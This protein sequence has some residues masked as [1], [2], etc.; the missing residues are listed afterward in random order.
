MEGR[1]S[2]Y[3]SCQS[4]SHDGF[5]T[6]A[7]DGTS[8][9]YPIEETTSHG[10]GDMKSRCYCITFVAVVACVW[11]SHATAQSSGIFV[12]PQTGNAG[13][14]TQ[15]PG[16]KLDIRQSA[17]TH[18]P[19]LNLETDTQYNSPPLP[20]QPPQPSGV[21]VDLELKAYSEDAGGQLRPATIPPDPTKVTEGTAQIRVNADHAIGLRKLS[22]GTA[23][24]D[25]PITFEPNGRE[26]LRIDGAGRVGIGTA[27]PQGALHIL[28]P[29][30]PP[31]A[32]DPSQNGLLVGVQSTAG[33]K[34]MQSYGGPLTLNPQGNSVGIG[35]VTPQ[36]PL[37]CNGS[38]AVNGNTVI[39]GRQWTGDPAGMRGP[40]GMDGRNGTDGRNGIN[41]TN[42][43]DGMMGPPGPPGPSVK[44]V[45]VC[46]IGGV[47]SNVCSGRVLAQAQHQCQI[48]AETGSCSVV[49]DPVS[50]ASFGI[51]CV[52]GQ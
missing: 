41:G 5:G 46:Q 20:G 32:L 34:W 3:Y 40:A 16:A 51:C 13:I 17:P 23:Q 42:G 19:T 37:E 14:G 11:S 4:P 1:V 2:A 45:A 36:A 31:N 30:E 27:E 29:G 21:V 48:T 52:C 6:G 25:M 33:Y 28:A 39:N 18:G 24:P 9:R 7:T 49:P 8:S 38:I 50:G 47:C 26:A 15:A 12:D 43:R 44:S 22:V 35:T 10:R